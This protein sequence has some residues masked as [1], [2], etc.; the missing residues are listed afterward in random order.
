MCSLFISYCHIFTSISPPV[1][2]RFAKAYAD[3]SHY[4]VLLILTDGVITDM[5]QTK[6]A[7]VKV[8][9]CGETVQVT[10]VAVSVESS[11][12]TITRNEPIPELRP[13]VDRPKVIYQHSFVSS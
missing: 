13:L 3:G 9:P 6:E 4:F 1:L 5:P 7:I 8:S 10:T 12:N 11:L 2:V